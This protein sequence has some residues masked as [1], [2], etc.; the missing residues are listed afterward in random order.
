MR[1]LEPSCCAD[2][3]RLGEKPTHLRSVGSEAHS[4]IAADADTFSY[5]T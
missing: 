5:E 3:R 1:R 2:A 4:G